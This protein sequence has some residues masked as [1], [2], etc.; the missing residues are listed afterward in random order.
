VR[1]V[2]TSTATNASGRIFDPHQILGSKGEIAKNKNNTA[3]Q[4]SITCGIRDFDAVVNESFDAVI[5]LA[6]LSD[7]QVMEW[8]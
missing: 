1:W 8:G 4:A 5:A 2:R 3:Y 7:K 6:S